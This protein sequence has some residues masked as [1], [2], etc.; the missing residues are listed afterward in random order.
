MVC[1][2]NL[3][4]SLKLKLDGIGIYII[5]FGLCIHILFRRRA[6]GSSGSDSGLYLTCT[7]AL[8]VLATVAVAAETFGL[9]QQTIV[10]FQASKTRDFDLLLEY[11]RQDSLKTAWV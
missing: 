6:S 3:G 8:F 1:F 9:A 11:L 5:I 4:R 7:I 10:G 2:N